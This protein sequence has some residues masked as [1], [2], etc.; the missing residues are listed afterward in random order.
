MTTPAR[1]ATLARTLADL[2]RA[3]VH[4]IVLTNP[5]RDA[6][7]ETR[8]AGLAACRHATRAGRHLLFL[9]DDIRITDPDLLKHHLTAALNANAITLLCAVNRTHYPPDALTEREPIR[10]RLERMPN[11]G[12]RTGA[13]GGLHGSMA[14]LIP[15]R[16]ARAATTTPHLFQHPDGT[17]L[18]HPVL[19]D[20]HQ[21]DRVTGF[22]FYLRHV[23]RTDGALVAVPNPIDHVGADPARERWRSPTAGRKWRSD[24]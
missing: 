22:D 19:P 16:I 11:P 2:A 8:A 6:P 4:P 7:A 5:G 24:A 17:L 23:A 14:V 3:D 20:D 1:A 10:A 9:E 12:A 21:H 18:T 13:R 15:Y